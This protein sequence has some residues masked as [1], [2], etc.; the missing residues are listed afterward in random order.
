MAARKLTLIGM[1]AACLAVAAP[2]SAGTLT[3]NG[4]N[5]SG[6]GLLSFTP[7]LG[8]SLTIGAGH[9]ASGALVTDFFNTFG[10]CAGGDCSIVGGY[11]TLTSGPETSGVSSGGVFDYGFGSGGAVDVLGKVP[12]LGINST[13]LL[14]SASFGGG[15]SFSGAGTVGS[16]IA[17]LNLASIFLDP[18]FGTYSYTGATGDVLSFSIDPSCSTGGM[19]SGS[20]IQSTVALETTPEPSAML[21]LGSALAG[22][23]LLKRRL[24]QARPSRTR[25]ASVVMSIRRAAT[26]RQN[27]PRNKFGWLRSFL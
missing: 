7:G 8:N 27:A 19:C 24:Y 25:L 10:V 13:S 11:L 17:S 6:Q 15:G 3:F 22:F 20:L 14:I 21:L 2:V 23:V 5:V 18:A 9:G 16:Q 1:L 12:S 4:F 26:G